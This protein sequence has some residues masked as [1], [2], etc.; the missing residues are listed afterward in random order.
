[1]KSVDILLLCLQAEGLQQ[2]IVDL[3]SEFEYDRMDY[4]DS[5]RKQDQQIKWLESVIERIHPCLR[6]DCNYV[7]LDRVKA[8]SQW[9]EEE[10]KWVLPRLT[11]DKTNLPGLCALISFSG[12]IKLG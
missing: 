3:Q 5:I 12:V 4:L 1:M 7:N 6:R 9:N 10:N 2:E 8:L 11:V